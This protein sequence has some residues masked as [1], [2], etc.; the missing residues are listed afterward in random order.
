MFDV[1]ARY[2]GRID[3]AKDRLARVWR[4]EN[5]DR[6]AFVF[7]DVNYAL[8]GQYDVPD[9]YYTPAKMFA[10]QAAKIER[11]MA[12]IDDDYLPVLYPWF[13]TAVLPSALGVAVRFHK[14]M[15]P[16]ADG[17]VV[18]EPGDVGRLELPDP[19]SAGLMPAVLEAIDYFRANS[20]AA[21]SVTDTQG[22]LTLALTLAG[23]E[24]LFVWMYEQPGAVH[25]L[26][27][28][29]TEALI[30]WLRVQKA[31]AGHQIAGDAW[32][33]AIGLPA[34]FG[35]VAFSDDDMTAISAQHYREFV[36]PRNEKLLGAFG[37][38]TIHMC[39]SARHQIENVL[40]TRGCTGVNNFLMGD[41]GQARLLRDGLRGRGALMACDFNALD[42]PAHCEALRQAFDD[43]AGAV[44]SVLIAPT[45]ALVGD[46]YV[47]SA[48]TTDDIVEQYVSLLSGQRPDSGSWVGRFSPQ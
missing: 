18:T 14:G 47:V 7:G 9:D 42:I 8:C 33:H 38:G 29:C 41:Y 48:R 46:K 10:Y 5:R 24:T 39:G 4:G 13:G 17:F 2:Q 37:G 3:A 23:V 12:Q 40:A 43:P 30:Q 25:A 45:M 1:V 26:L 35:G 28:F 19:N 22:P 44:V 27:D 20:D 6:P 32:P 36:M 21:V 16:E 15:D 31:H 11:H 34:G